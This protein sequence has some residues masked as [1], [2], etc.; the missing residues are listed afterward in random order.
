MACIFE[1]TGT[2]SVTRV[3]PV[4][5]IDVESARTLIE[6]IRSLSTVVPNVLI[7]IGTAQVAGLT[8]AACRLLTAAGFPAQAFVL[9]EDYV[10]TSA[11]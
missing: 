7:E 10:A 5:T 2:G 4:G 11:A 3:E 1:L 9:G 6:T 8:K